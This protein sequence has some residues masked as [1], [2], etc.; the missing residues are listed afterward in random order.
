MSGRNTN[1]CLR[2]LFIGNSY[3]AVNDLPGMF[4]T[5]SKAG[6]H[7][8][9]VGADA[10]G[11]FSLAQHLNSSDTLEALQSSKWDFVVLQEQSQIPAMEQ[12][13]SQEMFPAARAL[14]QKVRQAGAQPIFF[15]T[16]AHRDGWPEDNLPDYEGMQLQINQG[17]MT[18][19]NELKTQVAPV[20]YAWLTV[21]L[22]D[23][24]LDLWQADGSHPTEQGTY[25]AACVFY[26]VIF[27]QSPENNSYRAQ[28][29]A[30]VAHY[31]QSVASNIVLSNPNNW[32][33]P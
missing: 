13:R 10:P 8:I 30:S 25:L 29:S 17:Y 21:W 33:L 11:G 7:S 18:I 5:L 20:G 15:L 19:A 2:V 32:N 6:G 23:P 14:V 1:P 27:R 22:Q 31:L 4:A 12:T 9:Q 24:K 3:T 16:W 26:A 28:L